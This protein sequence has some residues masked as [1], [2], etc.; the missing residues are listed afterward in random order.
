MEGSQRRYCP[1]FW[2]ML[3]ESNLR[4]LTGTTS[5]LEYSM[6]RLFAEE[7]QDSIQWRQM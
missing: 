1:E 2:G 7:T 4:E 3:E 5:T 6:M